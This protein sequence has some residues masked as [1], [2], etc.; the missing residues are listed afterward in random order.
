[1]NDLEL[2]RQYTQQGSQAAF[3]TVVG[4]HVDLVHSVAR[5]HVSS[6]AL[7]QEITQAVFLDLAR[8]AGTL[9]PDSHVA[10][11]LH[12]VA[13]RTSI[14]AVRREV[15]RQERE[16]SAVETAALMNGPEPEWGS[17]AP[18]LDDAI[19]ALG[20]ED[21]TAVLLRYFERKTF[22]DIGEAL[23]ASEEAARKRVERGVDR[24]R[25]LL[26]DRGVATT[27]AGLAAGI[28]AN[29]VQAAPAALAGEISAL[30][31]LSLPAAIQTAVV[32]SSHAIAMTT[33]QKTAFVL[34]IA[35]A[36]TGGLLQHRLI[37][38]QDQRITALERE[39]RE[40][41]ARARQA[42]SDRA[43]AVA[44]LAGRPAPARAVARPTFTGPGSAA[45][46]SWLD[47]VQKLHDR[48]EEVPTQSIPE[49][50]LLKDDDWL[51]AAK[52][53]LSTE[54]D[55]RQALAQLR[56]TAEE[57]LFGKL[58]QALGRYTQANNGEF[59]TSPSDLKPYVDE[60]IDDEMLQRQEIIPASEIPNMRLGGDWVL[61]QKTAVDDLF[62][63]R[64]VMGPVGSGV[65]GG[66]TPLADMA[67]MI[68]IQQ[69]YRAAN[70]GKTPQNSAEL[71]PYA[72]TP[73]QQA[74][75]QR[76]LDRQEALKALG[77][78]AR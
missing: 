70:P 56:T 40:T 49:F 23:G 41:A 34:V 69:A 3:A 76:H 74:A 33:L 36:V 9:R 78:G 77:V 31:T 67:A 59:P 44:E 73:D 47:R 61:T 30:A 52:H 11:W 46:Q 53:E 15:R 21:R 28:A 18:L 57:A 71:A 7:A 10:A 42:E 19:A 43:A 13:R 65:V 75:L 5:R 29:A 24:L 32:Q 17:V 12:T 62:D 60:S 54:A 63:S 58:K 20:D 35:A 38:S 50:K 51:A 72:T 27:G 2:L 14:D 48:I 16:R 26:A 37:E 55:Y 25:G 22:R 64:Q 8:H 45:I 1:M 68:A 6:D 66:F 39:N 4:R